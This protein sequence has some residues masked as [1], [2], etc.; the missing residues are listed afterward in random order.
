MLVD[1]EVIDKVGKN[2]KRRK[3]NNAT[4]VCRKSWNKIGGLE[5][6]GG[7]VGVSVRES[8]LHGNRMS[9]MRQR[10]CVRRYFHL[11]V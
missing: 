8:Q 3:R 1:V 6:C 10:I 11:V 4:N 5:L 7:S 9:R 2:R